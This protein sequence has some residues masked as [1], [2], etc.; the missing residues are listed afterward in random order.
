M[1]GKATQTMNLSEALD[2][3]VNALMVMKDK[4]ESNGLS[5]MAAI[6]AEAARIIREHAATIGATPE[7][8]DYFGITIP[9]WAQ[10][11][12]IDKNYEVFAY[13]AKPHLS[14]SGWWCVTHPER[15]AF[16]AGMLDDVDLDWRDS[17]RERPAQTAVCLLWNMVNE[18]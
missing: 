13:S 10:Y 14:K 12:A 17:L 1:K 8:W 7:A 15:V 16:I 9:A 4:A 18:E 11:A 3:A 5:D 2:I 6:D